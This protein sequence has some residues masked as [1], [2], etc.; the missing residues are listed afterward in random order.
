MK[1]IG[2][3][4]IAFGLIDLFGSYADFDLWGNLGVQLP[5]II[6]RFSAYIEIALGYLLVKQG[7][8]PSEETQQA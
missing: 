8:N 5:E 2:I 3:L 4:L 7:S 1:I 6:W